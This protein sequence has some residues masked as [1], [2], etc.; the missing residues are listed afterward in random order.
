MKVLIQKLETALAIAN[1]P[2]ANGPA[3]TTG[4]SALIDEYCGNG[5]IRFP[6]PPRPRGIDEVLSTTEKVAGAIVFS[7][8]AASIDNT[9]IATLLADGADK[10]FTSALNQ[11]GSARVKPSSQSYTEKSIA[12]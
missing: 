11:L 1:V 5:T 8:A 12:N 6:F 4:I 7:S 9:S 3:N 10:I 2:A